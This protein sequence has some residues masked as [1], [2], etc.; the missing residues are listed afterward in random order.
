MKSFLNSDRKAF[1]FFVFLHTLKRFSHHLMI[2][3]K[4]SLLMLG[5]MMAAMLIAFSGGALAESF[6][7]TVFP[8]EVSACPCSAVTPQQ[9]S[10]S[11][12]NLYQTTDSYTFDLIAPAGWDS[13]IQQDI[14]LGSGEDGELDLF[15]INVGC[16]VPPGTYTAAVTARS[17][18]TGDSVSRNLQIEVLR[19]RGAELGVAD[20]SKE[21]CLEEPFPVTYGA[22]LRNLGKFQETFVLSSATGGVSFSEAEVTLDG[23][24]T[25]T[26]GVVVNPESM[27]IG[28][29]AT[30][31]QARSE[32]PN[33]PFFYTPITGEITLEVRDC[34][35]FTAELQPAEKSVCSGKSAEYNLMIEN[36]GMM[37]DTY[38]LFTPGWVSCQETEATLVPGQK[39]TLVVVATPDDTGTREVEVTVSSEKGDGL[40]RKATASLVSQECR[41]VAVIVSP[42]EYIVCGGIPPISLDVSVKNTG[43][44]ATTYQIGSSMGTIEDTEFLLEPGEAMTTSLEIDITGLSGS[45]EVM[46]TAAS[47]EVYDE[48]SVGLVVE[49]CYSASL[50]ITPESQSVCPYDSVTYTVGLEN[51]GELSDTYTVRYADETET[52]E[53]GPGESQASELTFLVPFEEPGIYVV[54]ASAESGHVSLVQT[55]ALNVKSLQEC[56][57]TELDMEGRVEIKP[58]TPEECKAEVIPAKLTN[59]GEKPTSYTLE[60]GGPEW[61]YME[62][63]RFDLEPGESGF[64]YVYLSPGFDVGEGSYTLDLLIRSEHM[65]VLSSVDVLITS[66]PGEPSA[67][68]NVSM[69]ASQG[70]ITGA[71]VGGE[72]PLWKTVVVAII[73][74]V[75]VI[76][77][78]VRF[79]LLV[80]R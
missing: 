11:V 61:A 55:A 69:N 12:S 48:A 15:L 22:T 30:Q 72:R 44:V 41:S 25:R 54:S 21:S 76:I 74:I 29:H 49:N 34:Y 1:K 65:D 59:A 39:A 3:K 14:T 7:M 57:D 63:T 58:C 5:T 27:P 62:P 2:M 37:E 71:V 28:S 42:P 32:D 60:L 73:A 43:T 77:L 8:E 17:V 51:K 50:T 26:I 35:D 10:V 78:I 40:S 80:K 6:E 19:C 45:H 9:V 53:L 16:G 56:Y 38:S 79:I 46:V 75:I 24:E 64:A 31:L 70:N 47:G 67:T 52:A 4:G 18:T 13:S 66:E 68:P 23:G 33:S 36:T 20:P